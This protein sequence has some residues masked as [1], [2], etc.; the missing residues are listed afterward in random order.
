M[1]LKLYHLKVSIIIVDVGL[2]IGMDGMCDAKPA[3]REITK[4]DII[5]IVA[6]RVVSNY[7]QSVYMLGLMKISLAV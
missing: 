1:V 7:S 2:K 6:C 5:I 4:I 3:T